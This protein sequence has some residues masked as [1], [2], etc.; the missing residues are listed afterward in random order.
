MKKTCFDEKFNTPHNRFSSS[1]TQK[2]PKVK[3]L[4]QKSTNDHQ[5]ISPLA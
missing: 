1:T 2:G 4:Q 5:Y 3:D